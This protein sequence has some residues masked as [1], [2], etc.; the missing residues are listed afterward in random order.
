MLVQKKQRIFFGKQLCFFRS[1]RRFKRQQSRTRRA[2]KF[3][4]CLS[5][6]DMDRSTR[7]TAVATLL[8]GAISVLASRI[9][10]TLTSADVQPAG[11]QIISLGGLS[12]IQKK[13]RV[14]TRFPIAIAAAAIVVMAAV[15]A[16]ADDDVA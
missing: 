14:M 10:A 3:T 2:Q 12:S 15:P 13:E 16:R 5:K 11:S 4:V 6:S 8:H 9:S 1:L 7:Y